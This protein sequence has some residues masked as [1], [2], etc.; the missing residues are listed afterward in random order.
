M[1]RIQPTALE[2]LTLDP[3][4]IQ[5]RGRL[6]AVD[7]AWAEVIAASIKQ[8][9]QDTPV[10]LRRDE[11]GEYVLVAGAHRLEACRRLGIQ[12]RA[13][14][15]DCGELEARL[16]EIDENLFRRELSPLD[17]AVFLA[18]RQDVYE[19]LFPDTRK[20]VAG[21]KARQRSATD[22]MSVAV[23]LSFAAETAARTGFTERTI[24]R[25]VSIARNI[26]AALRAQLI[27]TPIADN[28][29][30]LLHLASLDTDIQ[31]EAV[32]LV[33]GGAVKTVKA[34][35]ARIQGVEPDK[36]G[37]VLK[38]LTRGWKDASP[39]T[40]KRFLAGLNET[41]ELA[42]LIERIGGID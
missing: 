18:E 30:E 25:A 15:R 17:R 5:V 14:L 12:I 13:E 16:A 39:A 8:K 37:A 26:P 7:T 10:Q 42:D 35:V 23:A 21:G 28:Q 24:R 33:M 2:L 22:T 41:G 29:A 9:G 31:R 4:E 1:N 6:R 3:A 32:A 36:Q 34:A 19:E 27:G 40:K 11:A 38:A 20:D